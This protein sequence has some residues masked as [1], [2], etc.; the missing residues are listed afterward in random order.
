MTTET[1]RA[2]TPA[3]PT[4]N[5]WQDH[6]VCAQTDPAAF[7]KKVWRGLNLEGVASEAFADRF[8]SKV[9]PSGRCWEWTAY[10]KPNG[11]GAFMLRKGVF[12]GAHTVSFALVHGP[13]PAGMSICHKCDNPPCVNPD[14]LFLGTQRDNAFDMFAKGRAT[15][16]RGTDRANARLTE[17][18]VRAIREPAARYGLIRALAREHGVSE[19]TVRK[20]RLGKKWRHVA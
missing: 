14:H 8:W 9:D 5:N 7:R 13:I 12:V 11:Y 16:T 17:D 20:I 15:R 2:I 4:S 19:T 3:A 10:R 6:A 18:A 1:S